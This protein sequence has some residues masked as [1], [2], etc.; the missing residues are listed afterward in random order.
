MMAIQSTVRATPGNRPTGI[1][2]LDKK[3][4]GGLPEG[5]L[6][7]IYANPISMPEAFLYHFASVVKTYYFVTSR[8]AEYV[9]VNIENMGFS[10]DNIEFVDV[11]SQYYMNEYGQFVIIDSYR[12]KE[13]FDFVDHQLNRIQEKGGVFNVI[14]D[15]ISFFLKL[16]VPVGMKEWL[17]NK[18]YIHA[19]QTNNIYCIYL[20]KGVHPSE[21]VNMVLEVSDVIFDIDT[22]ILGDRVVSKLSIPKIRNRKPMLETFK[23]FIGEGVQIDTSRDIA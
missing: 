12:D 16:D 8:P 4:E 3:L 6:V 11:F 22:E 21:I 15:S 2:I 17:V 14:F 23:Y 18:L 5:S 7:C 10:A 20:M 13:I 19:K 9:K 1:E